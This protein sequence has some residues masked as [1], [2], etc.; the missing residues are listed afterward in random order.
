MTFN[1]QNIDENES[2]MKIHVVINIKKKY[3]LQKDCFRKQ[4]HDT[5]TY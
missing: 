5:I 3:I 4:V 2:I 1:D